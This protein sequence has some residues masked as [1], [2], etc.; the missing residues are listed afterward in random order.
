MDIMQTVQDLFG[1]VLADH[2]GNQAAAARSLGI[3]SVTFHGWIRGN[4]KKDD[5]MLRA[6]ERAGGIIL[7]PGASSED[8]SSVIKD[9]REK[10]MSLESE[11]AV[12]DRQIAELLKYKYMWEG[13]ERTIALQ[14]GTARLDDSL[15]QK[16]EEQTGQKESSI[17]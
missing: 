5:T 6:I 16:G 7:P 4:R 1:K 8:N 17:K 14:S 3:N 10:I 2:D 11:L 13:H 15:A 9:L 12:K